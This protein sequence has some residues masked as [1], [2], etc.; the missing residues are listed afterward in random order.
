MVL[1]ALVIFSCVNNTGCSQTSD[2]YYKH[3]PQV[4]E[5]IK[6]HERRAVKFI[7]PNVIR[8]VGPLIHIISTNGTG[9]VNVYPGLN[10]ELNKQKLGINYTYDF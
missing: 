4:Y 9:T 2:L 8:F 3:N 10:I 7:G 6:I 1:E 5:E